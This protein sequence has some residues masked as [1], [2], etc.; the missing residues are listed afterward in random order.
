MIVFCV[1]GCQSV[2]TERA[3]GVPVAMWPSFL[4]ASQHGKPERPQVRDT[5]ARVLSDTGL[6][7]TVDDSGVSVPEGEE[8]RA[9]EVLLTD[10][11]LDGTGA[12]VLLDE[13]GLADVDFALQLAVVSITKAETDLA[14]AQRWAAIAG[15][16]NQRLADNHT[17][18]WIHYAEARHHVLE[19]NLSQ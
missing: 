5:V 8:R 19:G 6:H 17:Q 15:A 3:D 11:R 9:R 14:T 1:T 4:I 12:I 10:K 18:G 16:L 2:H 13:R 7:A